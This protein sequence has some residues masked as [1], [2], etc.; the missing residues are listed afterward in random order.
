[1]SRL[2]RCLDEGGGTHA[3]CS[4]TVDLARSLLRA[5]SVV[6]F[7]RVQGHLEAVA[8]HSP[9]G[10]RLSAW[11][12]VGLEEP[13]LE[14]ESLQTRTTAVDPERAIFPGESVAVVAPMGDGLLYLSPDP[15]DLAQLD[16]ELFEWL[17]LQSGKA[18]KLAG[19]SQALEQCREE[20]DQLLRSLEGM[21]C[22][23]EELPR[24]TAT[25]DEKELV[26]Q[27]GQHLETLI[28]HDSRAVLLL[29]A[30]GRLRIESV[31][32]D[33]EGLTEPH[34]TLVEGRRPLRIDRLRGTRW[35]EGLAG[36]S[37]LMAVPIPGHQQLLGTI[38][39]GSCCPEAFTAEHVRLLSIV[40]NQFGVTVVNAQL[41]SQVLE[42][43]QELR[44]T[45]GRQMESSKLAAVGQLAA[46]VAH[47]LNNPLG[48]ILLA[49]ELLPEILHSHP[50]KA[51][52]LLSNAGKAALRSK[53]IVEKLLVYSRERG[54]LRRAELSQVV[55]DALDL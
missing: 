13:L 51:Q 34:Q 32:F 47:E 27:L 44:D 23:L 41:H 17:A 52:R 38:F 49:T 11:E 28:P 20:R 48:T 14:A 40:A 36:H 46:G 22:I 25:L 30:Q 9:H 1:M 35:E 10:E 12:L 45:R 37:S 18:L 21:T 7:R 50:D 6:A 2:L 33:P 5:Q 54:A 39:L 31:G 4:L 29:D 15:P 24:L 26:E 55:G 43:Y 42:A 19:S 16:L 3:L 8:W 53:S